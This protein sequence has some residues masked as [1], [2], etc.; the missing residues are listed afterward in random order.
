MS[1]KS[2]GG[3]FGGAVASAVLGGGAAYAVAAW[4]PWEGDAV[5]AATAGAAALA[6]LL[7]HLAG[8]RNG[9]RTPLPTSSGRF[10]ERSHQVE[11]VAPPETEVWLRRARV[12]ADRVA[13]HA[14][15]AVR[16]PGGEPIGGHA[17]V[18]VLQEATAHTRVA[19][20]QLTERATAVTVIDRTVGDTDVRELRA[21]QSR[22]EREAATAPA[23]ALRDAKEASARAVADR[24]A[25]VV[26]LEELRR[27]LMAALESVTLRLEAV[28]EHG[29]VLL[30][31]QIAGEAAATAMDLGPLTDELLA[32]QTGLEQL[33]ELTRSVA[34]AG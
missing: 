3:A 7:A 13:E 4:A 24:V 2:G 21:E 33:E 18:S 26:R 8:A 12:A 27:T 31:A 32:V 28:A 17:L 15:A 1:E 29:G 6:A 22:L 10:V 30:S 16:G 9:R 14:G 11:L 23:G 34:A 19:A 5:L 20:E 25:S